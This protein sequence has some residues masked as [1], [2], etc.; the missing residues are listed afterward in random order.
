[1]S[2]DRPGRLPVLDR[3][4]PALERHFAENG[5]VLVRD[6]LP[7]ADVAELE[8]HVE[9]YRKWLLPAVPADWARYEPDGTVRGMYFMNRV[10]PWFA[11]FGER[12]D[13]ADLART[14]SGRAV[15]F[16]AIET[17]DKPARVGSSSLIHQDGIY[18]E[19]TDIRVLHIWIPLEEASYDNGAVQYWPGTHRELLPHEATGDPHLRAITADAAASL[20]DPLIAEV[21]PGSVSIHHDRVVHASPANTS[22]RPRRAVLV[23]WRLSG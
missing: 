23:A 6:A 22:G 13:L 10:D 9:R 17:F 20:P 11:G 8:R 18:F 12:E 21:G 7:L 19:G 15:K 3:A 4:D 14:V 16:D 1:M 2:N 5:V